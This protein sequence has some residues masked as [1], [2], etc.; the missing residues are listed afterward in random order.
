MDALSCDRRPSSPGP[1]TW[2]AVQRYVVG[3]VPPNNARNASWVSH[4]WPDKYVDSA[5]YFD[6]AHQQTRGTLDL[7]G[8]AIMPQF[9]WA[10]RVHK[11]K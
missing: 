1:A 9:K 10:E 2:T 4:H 5:F 7:D 8:I 3:R 6:F 11:L